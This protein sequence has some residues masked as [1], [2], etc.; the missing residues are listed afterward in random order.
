M[1]QRLGSYL[2][3]QLRHRTGGLAVTASG[4][5]PRPVVYGAN[6]GFGTQKLGLLPAGNVNV[7]LDSKPKKYVGFSFAH[8]SNNS[9]PRTK[10]DQC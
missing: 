4:H 3:P 6:A 7:P 2:T 9:V 1:H 5:L 8:H 10:S